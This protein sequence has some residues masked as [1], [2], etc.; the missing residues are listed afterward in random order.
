MA[1]NDAQ[2]RL[3]PSVLDR[4]IDPDPGARGR[5]YTVEQMFAAVQRDLEELLNTRQSHAGL[6]EEHTELLRSIYAY[7]LPD[8]TSLNAFTVQQRAEIGRV[9]EAIIGVFEPRLKDVRAT[10]VPPRDG[11]DRTVRF[12]VDAR[13]CLDPAPEVAFDTVLE[14]ATGHYDVKPTGA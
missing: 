14:L 6:P 11:W 12:R 9:I 8:L 2:E 10:L 13:L 3:M 1:T 7:G 5:G 4:L